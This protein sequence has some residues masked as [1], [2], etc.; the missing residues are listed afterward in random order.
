VSKHG[1]KHGLIFS[2]GIHALTDQ[3][4]SMVKVQVIAIHGASTA[5]TAPS[6]HVR[7]SL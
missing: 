3:S 4:R 5:S 1:C 7:V 6:I 2:G